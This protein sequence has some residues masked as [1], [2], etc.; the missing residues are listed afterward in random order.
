MHDI[1]SQCYSTA[2]ASWC[3]GTVNKQAAWPL[4]SRIG[5]EVK[6][7][8]QREVRI[9]RVTGL[10]LLYQALKDKGGRVLNHRLEVASRMGRRSGADG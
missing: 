9:V 1:V 5:H 4:Q 10:G 7:R 3:G 2:P 8:L 6:Q